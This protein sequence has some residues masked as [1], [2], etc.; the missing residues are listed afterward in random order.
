MCVCHRS[1]VNVST[2]VRVPLVTLGRSRIP[3]DKEAAIELMTDERI[4]SAY[5]QRS[6]PLD[7]TR[8]QV[9]KS[10]ISQ[11]CTHDFSFELKLEVVV[12]EK[13]NRHPQAPN[14]ALS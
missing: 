11:T 9:I 12:Q 1:P 7:T 4:C 13:E 14:I 6:D 5:Y 8:V 2:F 3:R 10:A